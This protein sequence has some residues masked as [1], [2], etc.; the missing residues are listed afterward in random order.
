[1]E[2]RESAG[3]SADPSGW[4]V[5]RSIFV[6]DDE[7]TAREYAHREDGAHGFYFNVMRTKLAKGGAQALM[8][9]DP[10]QSESELTAKRCLER[11]V[12]AGTPESVAEQIRA[13][14]CRHTRKRRRTNSRVS[15]GSGRIWNPALHRP[16]LDR[17]R[18][19]TPFDGT[20]G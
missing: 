20:H 13:F 5:A 6:A 3:L 11:L 4:R 7:D 18:P 9:D 19:R 12:I 14:R 10:G 8:L 17:P 1:L 2:G 15:R 16:R